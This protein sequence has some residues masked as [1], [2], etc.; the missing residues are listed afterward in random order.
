M[1][2]V[3]PIWAMI[4]GPR[5]ISRSKRPRIGLHHVH[6]LSTKIPN[7]NL[8]RAHDTYPAF[9]RVPTLSLWQG[10][11]CVKLTEARGGGTAEAG[12]LSPG[13]RL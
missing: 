11:K 1:F 10:M 7:Y 5:M 8:Q 12:D 2:G 13:S 4:I 6:H 3:G 9:Q